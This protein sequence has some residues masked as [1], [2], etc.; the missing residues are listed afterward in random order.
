MGTVT[1]EQLNLRLRDQNN[2]YVI[3]T[4]FRGNLTL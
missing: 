4:Y 3:V 1:I 2:K